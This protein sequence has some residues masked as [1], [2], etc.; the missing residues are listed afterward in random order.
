M[1]KESF[2]KPGEKSNSFGKLKN[3]DPLDDERYHPTTER[4]LL[5]PW[6]GHV[7]KIPRDNHSLDDNHGYYDPCGIN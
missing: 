4:S 3:H 5:K 2:F 7:R 6:R 1:S